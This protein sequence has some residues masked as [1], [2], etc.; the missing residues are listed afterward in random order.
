[1]INYVI[2]IIN[3]VIATKI[4]ISSVYMTLLVS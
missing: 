4:I 1:M 2:H 3:I